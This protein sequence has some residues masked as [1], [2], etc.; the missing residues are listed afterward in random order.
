[1]NIFWIVF[2][3]HFHR[4][5]QGEGERGRRG[6]LM[7]PLKRLEKLDHKNPIKHRNRGPPTQISL[8]PKCRLLNNLKMTVL[9]KQFLF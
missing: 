6:H 9:H 2:D 4:F 3:N 1:L 7:Y 8:N 5:T